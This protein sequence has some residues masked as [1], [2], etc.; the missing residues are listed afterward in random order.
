VNQ[1]PVCVAVLF[2]FSFLW[3]DRNIVD[4]S[5]KH[6]HPFIDHSSNQTPWIVTRITSV[7]TTVY[8]MYICIHDLTNL[9]QV[10]DKIVSNT[11]HHDIGKHKNLSDGHWLHSADGNLTTIRLCPLSNQTPW[12]V[13]RITSVF[14]TVYMMYICIHDFY[15]DI[16][17][18]R[19]I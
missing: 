18:F 1:S 7:F 2:I 4:S 17:V 14:T 8:M 3:V 11:P 6:L 9:L 19:C 10:T 5:A 15:F 13:T 16:P 12:I